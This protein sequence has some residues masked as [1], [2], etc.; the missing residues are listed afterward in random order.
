MAPINSISQPDTT[1]TYSY[2]DYLAWRFDESVGLTKGKLT[3]PMAGPS[4]LHRVYAGNLF[5]GIRQFLKEKPCQGYVA[6][7]DVRLNTPGLMVTSRLRP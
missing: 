6:P 1:K 4:R 2:A 7:F 3:R 5:G